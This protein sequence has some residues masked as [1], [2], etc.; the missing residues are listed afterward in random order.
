MIILFKFRHNLDY[1][2]TLRVLNGHCGE[3]WFT[4]DQ[5]VVLTSQSS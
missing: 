2:M 1:Y 5:G 4:I 3:L